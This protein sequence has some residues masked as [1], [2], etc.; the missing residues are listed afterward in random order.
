[1]AS[2][3][4]FNYKFTEDEFGQPLDGIHFGALI[5]WKYRYDLAIYYGSDLNTN[6][7]EGRCSRWDVQDYSI[8]VETWLLKEDCQ[9]L[10]S[11]I[12]PGAVGEL[13]K[14]YQRPIYKDKTW[15]G[16]NSLRLYP[17]PSSSKMPNS[18]LKA[19]RE[20]T[21]IYIKN[22]TEHPITNTDWIEIKLEGHVS[23][24]KGL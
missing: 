14:L 2:N 9:T 3:F 24:Q 6:F 5:E 17:T 11:N 8:L 15:T 19:M 13:Y 23:G 12:R 18:T 21:I 16:E 7:I 10:R 20:D 22:Y 1:M 4:H